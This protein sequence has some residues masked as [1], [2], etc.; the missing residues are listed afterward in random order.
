MKRLNKVIIIIL[1][2]SLICII[3]TSELLYCLHSTLLSPSHFTGLLDKDKKL[4]Q[5]T[6]LIFNSLSESTAADNNEAYIN[7]YAI[8]LLNKL[9]QTWVKGQ[10]YIAA[11]GI[12]KYI[13]SEAT[14]LPTFDFVPL[15]TVIKNS[16]VSELMKQPQTKGNIEKVKTVLA[17]LNNKYFSAI[18]EFGISNQLVTMLL[19]LAP[20]RSTGFDRAT[21]SEIIEIYLSFSNKNITLDQA[22]YSIVEQMAAKSLELD[23][24]KDYFDSNLFLEKAFS[25]NNPI[26]SFKTFVNRLDTSISLSTKVLFWCFVLLIFIFLQLSIPKL[27]R[28]I[29]YCT[30]IASV[31]NV[32]L[33]VLLINPYFSHDFMNQFAAPQGAFSSFLNKLSV[34]LLRDF[35][36]YLALQSVLIS[37][38]AV[39][40]Y[41][42]IKLVLRKT[43]NTKAT[44][45]YFSTWRFSLVITIFVILFSWW[46]FS[47]IKKDINTF[48]SS[49]D[50]LHNTDIKQSIIN[51]L[52]EAGGMEFLKYAQ[53]K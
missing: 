50:K 8:D 7:R 30:S 6:A 15:N 9:N 24:L 38:I 40:S 27:L 21:I 22:S 36:L 43:T 13:A 49:I 17:V 42:L 20:I 12:Q 25:D 3:S 2:V 47:S 48:N 23:K 51:G 31:F 41:M 14:T 11:T 46:N 33:S 5:L 10:I 18:I 34:F 26:T 19:E 1:C 29:L 16:L 28:I 35:G 39:I 4:S 44:V 37:I 53:K 52:K 45:R 32:L